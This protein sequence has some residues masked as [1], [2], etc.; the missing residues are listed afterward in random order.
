MLSRLGRTTMLLTLAALAGCY[1]SPPPAPPEQVVSTLV[2]LLNDPDPDIR[3]TAAQ[4]LG[5]IS[6]PSAAPA[7]VEHL[8]DPDPL[9]RRDSA[10]ALGALG[11]AAL[12]VAALPLLARLDDPVEEVKT[13]AAQAL[14]R[15]GPTQTM[16]ELLIEALHH[17]EATT[18]R[19]AAQALA[20]LEP[21]SAFH[22]LLEAL[23]DRD[24]GV[25]QRALAGLGEQADLRALPAFRARLLHDPDA[26]VRSEAAFRLGKL[27]GKDSVPTLRTALKH[28]PDP[29]VRRWAA[30]ALRQLSPTGDAESDRSPA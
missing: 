13:A 7:L 3:R 4:S 16:V 17:P 23:Q 15:M 20:W 27:G 10:W 28:D 26:G 25:R 19:E 1:Q 24:A 30:W 18:R 29:A 21:P 8:S 9:V 12:D 2:S 14:G 5:K 11:E 22:A 6:D